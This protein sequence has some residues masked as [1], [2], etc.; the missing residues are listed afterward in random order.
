[1]QFASFLELLRDSRLTRTVQHN[2]NHKFKNREINMLDPVLLNLISVEF[3]NMSKDRPIIAQARIKNA[4][5]SSIAIS[6]G[7]LP[8]NSEMWISDRAQLNR[9]RKFEFRSK[10]TQFWR[11]KN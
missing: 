1:M 4:W 9:S 8:F 2:T 3:S 7:N 6:R 11:W 5:K 10:F